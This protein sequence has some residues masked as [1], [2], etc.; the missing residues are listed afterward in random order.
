MQILK[1]SLIFIA[2]FLVG[3]P[4][5]Y[6]FQFWQL[7][8]N[9]QIYDQTKLN[10]I[11]L[12]LENSSDLPPESLFFQMFDIYL[13]TGTISYYV[14]R[15]PKGNVYYPSSEKA[16]LRES[17]Y[18]PN[19]KSQF[20]HQITLGS[21][22]YSVLFGKE[23]VSSLDL[24]L[25]VIK[26]QRDILFL[27]IIG[28]C[29]LIYKVAFYFVSFDIEGIISWFK[30]R[31]W[32]GAVKTLSEDAEKLKTYIYEIEMQREK[33]EN[34]AQEYKENA[35][36]GLTWALEKINQGVRTARISGCR[37]D[38][39]GY[40]ILK[41]TLS[42]EMLN[43][44]MSSFFNRGG[45]YLIRYGGFKES[46]A[47]DETV[48]FVPED[49][50]K[51]CH[52]LALHL[53]RGHLEIIDD[54]NHDISAT[55]QKLTAKASIEFGVVELKKLG[56]TAETEGT[57]FESAQRLLEVVK[58]K[59]SSILSILS[60]SRHLY[61]NHIQQYSEISASFKHF[62]EA[63][64][65]SLI[66][67]IKGYD[68]KDFDSENLQYFRTDRDI[69]G[70]LKDMAD[71]LGL[72]NTERFN[73]LSAHLKS[74]R[75]SRISDAIGQ[76]FLELFQ[77][78]LHLEDS[79]ITSAIALLARSLFTQD[80]VSEQIL[81]LL[82]NCLNDRNMRVVSNARLSIIALKADLVDLNLY[83]G[84]EN[85]RIA[86][87]S[88]IDLAKKEGLTDVCTEKLITWL[89]SSDMSFRLSALYAAYNILEY[90]TIRRPDY[91][92]LNEN[93]KR[94]QQEIKKI[95]QT[96]PRFMKWCHLYFGLQ[97]EEISYSRKSA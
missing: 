33:A 64:A 18:D 58:E 13:K 3:Y 83:I 19:N 30:G 70:I 11:S 41:R 68:P 82:Q 8:K 66:R 38:V 67:K 56:G 92:R 39:N 35:Y 50:Q 90:W 37:C 12:M 22:K 62:N 4:S 96:D 74:F 79:K 40:S 49:D 81:S 20:R 10:N 78:S 53:V 76:L 63:I 52:V 7:E 95:D 54:V 9:S 86:A 84:H 59:E 34:L 97:G 71:Q 61:L 45:E 15:D 27:F 42:P 87:D 48:F 2:I 26:E 72:E 73:L 31:T 23:D 5:L 89:R 57:P 85:S 14:I 24:L 46:A 29:L 6:L 65:I 32:T 17:Q 69:E 28:I 51:N 47:G 21:E 88:L 93:F 1:R 80:T 36:S 16:L 44:I 60:S 91:V 55:S 75:I 94:T 43:Y 25:Q 77:K